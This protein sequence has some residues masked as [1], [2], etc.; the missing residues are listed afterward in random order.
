MI[1]VIRETGC[2]LL[3]VCC[4]LLAMGCGN[5]KGDAALKT[6]YET[7]VL[8]YESR[9]HKMFIP[10]TLHGMNEVEIYP[11]VEGI[12]RQVNFLDGTRVTKGQTLFVIDQTEYQ[13]KVKTAQATL[14]AAKAQ[15]ETTRLR[16]ESNQRLAQK[17]I[18]SDYVVETSLNAYHVAQAAVQEAQS[19]LAIAQTNL[20]YCH[21]K[22]PIAGTTK[23]NGFKVGAL[24]NVTD[25]L[26]TVSDD[27]KV[28]AWFSYTESQLLEAIEKYGLRLTSEGLKDYSGKAAG[29]KMPPVQLQLKTGALYSHEGIVTE[30]G[31]IVDSSTGTVIC[32]ATFP[33]PDD[34]LR[35]GLSA[36]LIFPTTLSKVLCVPQT[37][38]VRLQN[39]M[40]FYRVKKDGTVEGVIC[41]AIPSNDGKEYYIS[42]GLN[43]GDEVVTRGARKLTNGDKIR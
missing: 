30:I 23:E 1:R 20:G 6:K 39:R 5:Q 29:D 41:E 38:A 18:I 26:C 10:A 22:S 13:L 7:K 37:A 15:M 2:W 24:A 36:T 35:S 11:Q 19:Q 28:Q 17:H 25:L 27:S 16:Y 9:V 31:A 8:K 34:E 14:A 3:A 43:E 12:I 4:L 40:Q 33:N 32:K 42:S 21:V